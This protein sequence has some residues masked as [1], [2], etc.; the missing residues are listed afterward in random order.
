M[1]ILSPHEE[2]P[3]SSAEM[4]AAELARH[5]PI[6]QVFSPPTR[7]AFVLLGIYSAAPYIEDAHAVAMAR[8]FIPRIQQIADRLDVIPARLQWR[9]D[10]SQGL[11]VYVFEE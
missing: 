1:R 11:F 8:N 5:Y 7:F 4:F 2:R 10:S 6:I 3:P 9:W